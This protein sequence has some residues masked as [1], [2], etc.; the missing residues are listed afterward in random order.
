MKKS[1][2]S[3]KFDIKVPSVSNQTFNVSLFW[4]SAYGYIEVFDSNL[5]E[6]VDDNLTLNFPAI[7]DDSARGGVVWVFR[8]YYVSTLI[9]LI[10]TYFVIAIYQIPRVRAMVYFLYFYLFTC[11]IYFIL[12]SSPHFVLV[13]TR[14]FYIYIIIVYMVIYVFIYYNRINNNTHTHIYV[15]MRSRT[16]FTTKHPTLYKSIF[17]SGQIKT[18]VAHIL[19]LEIINQ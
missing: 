1:N 12:H 6:L 16:F 17:L 14:I 5:H 18:T 4:F 7:R 10:Y 8:V 13:Y 11:N 15:C 2:N 9:L 3:K 19:F